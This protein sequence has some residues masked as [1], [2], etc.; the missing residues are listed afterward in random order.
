MS[1]KISLDTQLKLFDCLI[2]LMVAVIAL[3]GVLLIISLFL[4]NWQL[5]LVDWISVY[6]SVP[7]V[8]MALRRYRPKSY[9]KN[10][11]KF[12]WGYVAIGAVVLLVL[13]ALRLIPVGEITPA[14]Y[15]VFVLATFV[16][17]IELREMVKE[18]NKP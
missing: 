2:Y 17:I 15:F 13:F 3:S 11:L 7:V 6:I 1:F 4:P 18:L 14:T 5:G 10:D 9:N 8:F 16:F 12:V